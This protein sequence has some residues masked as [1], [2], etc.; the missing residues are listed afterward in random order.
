[1][2]PKSMRW[3]VWRMLRGFFLIVAMLFLAGPA[4]AAGDIDTCRDNAAEAVARLAA[5]DLCSQL[6]P[7]F[8]S[9]YNNRGLIYLRRGEFD[10]AL[11]DFNSAVKYPASNASRFIFLSNRGSVQTYRKQYDAALA[12]FAEARKLN[13]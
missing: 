6:R 1:M 13:P 7:S 5:Y 2:R 10:R 12:D 9:P 11:E 3:S 8:S 4:L